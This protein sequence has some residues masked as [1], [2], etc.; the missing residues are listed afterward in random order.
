MQTLL[1]PLYRILLVL[2]LLMAT[3]HSPARAQQPAHNWSPTDT[4][5]GYQA[6]KDEQARRWAA[7]HPSQR[8]APGRTPLARPACF[9]PFDT[10]ASGGWSRLRRDDDNSSGS[11]PLGF[12]FSLFGTIYNRVY[13]NT[14]GNITFDRPLDAYTPAGFP[15]NTPMIA[16]FWADVDTRGPD[17]RGTG[18]GSVWYKVFPDRLVVVWNRVGY[19][20]RRIDR[21]NT[22]QLVIK[23]NTAPGF[24]GNDVL[25]SYD[26]MQWT[27]GDTGGSGGFGRDL[28]TVGA[29]RG[30][31]VDYIQT[32]RFNINNDQAPNSPTVGAPGGVDW[33][34]GK[35]LGYE[36]GPRDNIPPA[37]AGLPA[38]NIITVNQ[39]E[40][41]TLSLQFSGPEVTQ[42]VNVTSELNGLCSA[43]EFTTE[44]NSSNPNLL[45]F[46]TGS[47]C[48]IG[49][50][51]VTFTAV[52]NGTPT[53]VSVFTLRV[54][55][56]PPLPDGQWTGAVS[57]DYTNP[58]NWNNNT[59]PGR[60]DNVTIPG[61]VVNFPV[62]NVPAAANSF[63]VADG[64]SMTVAAGGALSLSGNLTNNGIVSGAGTL[65]ATG[66]TTQQFGGSKDISIANLTV[67]PAGLQLNR[68]LMVA[69]VLLLNGSLVSNG[70]LTLRSDEN[71]TAMVVNNGAAV[72]VGSATVQRY[73]DP[74]LNAG[75]GYRQFAAPVSNTTLAD[76][77]TPNFSPR[78]NSNYNTAAN[79][80]SVTPFP[81]VFFYNQG[82]V[83]TTGNGAN[84]DFDKGWVSPASTSEPMVPGKGYTVNLSGGQVL[85]FVGTLGN[86]SVVQSALLRGSQ[87]QAGW[88]LLGNP[89]PAPID[90]TQA[91]LGSS[92]LANAVHVFKSSGQYS[93]TYASFVNGIGTNGGT[94]IIPVA[95]GF[96]VRT[97]APGITGSLNL[98]NAA[99]LTTYTN[100]ALQ[101][102]AE[103]RPL[104]RLDLQAANGSTE[105]AAI[106]FQSGAT[107][108]F[109]Q[110]FDAFRIGNSSSVQLGT[111]AGAE[112]L[113][114]NGL[115]ALGTSEVTVPLVVRVARAGAYSLRATDL[116]NLPSGWTVTLRDA[117]TGRTVDLQRNPVYTC[118]LEPSQAPTRFSVQFS[119]GRVL[120][121]ASPQLSAQVSVYPNPA[122]EQ[123]W[124]SLPA[125]K[126]PV[127]V[128]VLNALGQQVQ[129]HQVPAGRSSVAALPLAGLAK[130]V[131]TLR[132]SL[133]EGV[134]TKRLVVE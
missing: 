33:L 76:L 51:D 72:V 101:R 92:G 31:G 84:A 122:R 65:L 23:A 112:E 32:G 16:A 108:A 28:A 98:T 11:I 43:A 111:L 75:L 74:S 90:W 117:L 40:T 89:Y 60:T 114:I 44:N 64:A 113:A 58:A 24:T 55:V 129:R 70:N 38:G 91:F 131:Y 27:S 120:A 81:N 19:F 1:S 61:G 126:Q 21:K 14:N 49:T 128:L 54:V 2:V 119:P 116:L 5:P 42:T 36:V 9:E 18:S 15:I 102:T 47:D 8:Y 124:L 46:V 107:A 39:G 85:D 79:P 69:Q 50:T 73:L 71:G 123:V 83:A 130:G 26:D 7:G 80:G 103:T 20:S 125:L 127:E 30:N 68:P 133:S 132:I 29:N 134:V 99:R 53:G 4:D 22:F 94:S 59:V 110:A 12:N 10:T 57:T 35:C 86:G 45:F 100:A 48:N 121:N 97:S 66:T 115:P 13:I 56:N 104:L 88:H 118:T 63:T 109:D 37:V 78:V 25:I 82:L 93:G 6:R 52:D 87:D 3:W 41:R 105:Q 62:L 77:A 34:D 17:D 67:G 96:L 95:Q 106:Y